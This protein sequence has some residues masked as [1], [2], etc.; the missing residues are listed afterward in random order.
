MIARRPSIAALLCS[1]LPAWGQQ[2]GIAPV[3][4]PKSAILRPYFATEVPPVRLSNSSRL[5]SLIRAGTLY[6]T[7]QDAIALALEN[8]IDLEIARYN[9]VIA[10]WR[11]VRAEAGGL[12]PGVP[13]NASQA[14]SVALGQG[15]TGSQAAA[16]VRIPGNLGNGNQSTNATISQIGPVTQTLDPIIQEASTFSHTTTPQPNLV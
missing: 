8:N 16:G 2:A 1:L 14:G 4:A 15:V 3:A 13:S 6:L 9:S 12:L 10:T 11:V 5:R 7:R